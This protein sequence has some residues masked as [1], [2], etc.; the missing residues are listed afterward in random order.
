[1]LHG[2]HR[3]FILIY[4]LAVACKVT[5]QQPLEQQPVV[6][7]L[8]AEKNPI[9][10][11]YNTPPQPPVKILREAS[12]ITEKESM[13]VSDDLQQSASYTYSYYRPVY[14]PGVYYSYYPRYR[15]YSPY[16]YYNWWYY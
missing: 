10:A 14:Y 3:L 2:I 12:P 6:T 4:L 15:W 11:I 9:P 5:H 8:D 16:Y 1:M 7:L 13:K